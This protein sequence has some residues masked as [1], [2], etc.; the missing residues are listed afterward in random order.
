M[1]ELLAQTTDELIQIIHLMLLHFE[2]IEFPELAASAVC[3]KQ[4][5]FGGTRWPTG[6]T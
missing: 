2:I 5:T 6:F 1:K 3:D 4:A